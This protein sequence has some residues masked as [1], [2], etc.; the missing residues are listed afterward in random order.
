MPDSLKNRFWRILRWTC[1]LLF[2]YVQLILGCIF[3]L[4]ILGGLL[5]LPGHLPDSILGIGMI[6][7]IILV[8]ILL[9]VSAHIEAA[10]KARIAKW[11]K[12][13]EEARE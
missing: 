4:L 6:A 2:E 11:G 13:A 9:L 10:I 1:L 12:N 8:V 5:F 7:Y 3:G